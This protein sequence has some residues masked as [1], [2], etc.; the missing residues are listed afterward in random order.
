MRRSLRRRVRRARAISLLPFLP[1]LFLLL[2]AAGSA[3]TIRRGPSERAHRVHHPD[4]SDSENVEFSSGDWSQLGRLQR[5][6]YDVYCCSQFGG[7]VGISGDTIVVGDNESGSRSAVT[8]LSGRLA[9]G[10][11]CFPPRNSSPA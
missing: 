1:L 11:T 8:F 5:Y 6:K 7:S 4:L 9:A 10:K 3:Q 2:S